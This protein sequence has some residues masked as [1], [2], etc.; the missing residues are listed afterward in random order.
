MANSISILAELWLYVRQNQ[1][2]NPEL[3]KK[4]LS[5]AG[6]IA[7]RIAKPQFF[8]YR[9]N[10]GF[11]QSVALVQYASAFPSLSNS[12]K[13]GRLGCSR[14]SDQLKYYI[15]P[16]GP[17]LEHSAGYHEFGRDLLTISIDLADQNGCA[18]SEEWRSKLRRAQSFSA[19]LRR[20][21]GSLPVFGNTD[22]GER[23]TSETDGVPKRPE[24]SVSWLP[25]SG[26]AIWW[27]GLESWPDEKWLAQT[28]VAWSNF[29]TRAH[30][31]ADDMSVLI[32]SQG[33]QWI[34]NVGYWPYD[35]R[36][37]AAAQGWGGANA[38][39]FADESPSA[40]PAARLRGFADVARL[41]AIELDRLTADGNATLR[42]QIVELDGS[43]WLVAD[44][45]M[46][47]RQGRVERL[48][49]TSPEI[50]A[51]VA[52]DGRA[53][54]LR[55][56]DT[57]ASA[58][59]SLLGDIEVR[60]GLY[61]GEL[62]PFAGWLVRDGNTTPASAISVAQRGPQSLVL[63]VLEAGEERT[64]R[65][66][67]L[68][69]LEGGSTPDAW[70]VTLHTKSGP[71]NVSWKR[72]LITAQ[73]QD[74]LVTASL[75]KPDE[76]SARAKAEIAAAYLSMTQRFTRFR[77]LTAYRYKLTV[78]VAMLALLQE[79]LLLIAR[80][81]TTLSVLRLRMS[82]SGVWLSFGLFCTFVFLK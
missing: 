55:P 29:P 17:V 60:P 76:A 52:P 21:D 67:S 12:E 46:G 51:V 2:L 82:A 59:L 56:K 34:T 81:W 35:A 53:V 57:D 72:G 61:R 19:L 80:R 65:A 13:L 32:R 4:I 58:R 48:W 10:H 25:L 47:N 15:S 9:T 42:R 3:G 37:Y 33:H 7:E 39:H 49:T 18:V 77:D 40:F 69:T 20:P 62:E 44:A 38:P 74:E 6:R 5:F 28:V 36:G 8:T 70:Q 11:M 43:S 14:L 41:R 31:H 26:Y 79:S 27:S 63:S 66:L 23:M 71:L 75:S 54:M 73:F 50:E 22:S 68:P 64:V 78:L 45:V 1:N 16:E 30:K 24:H